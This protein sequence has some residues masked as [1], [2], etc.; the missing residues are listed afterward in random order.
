MIFN[1]NYAITIGIARLLVALED[2]KETNSS[3]PFIINDNSTKL[4]GYDKALEYINGLKNQELSENTINTIH[5]LVS[6]LDTDTVSY[7]DKQNVIRN[8]KDKIIYIPPKVKDIKPLLQNLIKWVNK[9]V[10]KGKTPIL[11]IASIVHYQIATIHPFTNGNGKT[12][13]LVALLILKQHGYP[14]HNFYSLET[15]FKKNALA[16]YQAL[17]VSSTINYY[18]GRTE[19]DITDFISFSLQAI[20]EVQTFDKGDKTKITKD[21]LRELSSPQRKILTLFTDYKEVSSH[22]VAKK[23]KIKQR[24]ATHLIKKWLEKGFISISNPSNKLRTY[25]LNSNWEKYIKK[26]L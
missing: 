3:K 20:Y 10:K 14:L 7:R 26:Q 1:P 4:S 21:N 24:A 25:R 6:P 23:L 17:S 8:S 9:E 22:E 12:A 15:Y 2:K 13:R 11:I 19:A 5:S 16:Y 18:T